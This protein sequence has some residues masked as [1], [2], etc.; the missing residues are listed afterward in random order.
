V[1]PSAADD[2]VIRPP[3]AWAGLAALLGLAAVLA[4]PATRTLIDWQP[5][6]AFSEPWRAWT[7]AAVHYSA[8]HLGANLAGALLVGALGVVGEVSGRAVWAWIAAWPLTHLGLLARPELAHYGGLSGVL[9]AGAAVAAV[10]VLVTGPRSRR[11]IGAGI[12]AGLGLKVLLEQPWG[13]ALAHP[14]EWDIAIAPL[15]H[16][17]GALSG[18]V[19][20]LLL[21]VL[22]ALREPPAR[23]T[24]S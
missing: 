5:A 8:L 24:S 13:P 21:L 2:S 12:L 17:S 11:L 4:W 3:F 15:A 1:R 22:P 18:L 23:T 10:H 16:A 20:A 14:P 6:L 9:H 7:A 19:C